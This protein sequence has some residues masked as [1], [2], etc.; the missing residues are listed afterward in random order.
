M[1]KDLQAIKE[2]E[3]LP[4]EESNKILQG[5]MADE[6]EQAGPEPV[7][8]ITIWNGLLDDVE[9]NVPVKVIVLEHDK[10]EDTKAEHPDA[11]VEFGGYDY[12]VRKW[13]VQADPAGIGDV[14]Q[15][16]GGVA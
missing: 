11:W 6:Q 16:V 15:E 2:I 12:S 13:D 8:V 14:V 4:L 3:V 1:I 9:A 5:I 7:V 10:Y